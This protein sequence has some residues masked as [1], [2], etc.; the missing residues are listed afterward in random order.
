MNHYSH[1]ILKE[2]E[3]NRNSLQGSYLPCDVQTLYST[4][5]KSC[6]PRK[7][8]DDTVLFQKVNSLFLEHQWSPE[9][10]AARLKYEES[11]YNISFTTIYRAIYSGLFDERISLRAAEDVLEN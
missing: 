7:K 10:I 11:V 9:Q 5:R 1:F 4:R 2:R 6:R 8:L 3:L